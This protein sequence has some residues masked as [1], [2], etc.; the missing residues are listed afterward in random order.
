M[1]TWQIWLLGIG[2]I[3]SSVGACTVKTMTGTATTDTYVDAAAGVKKGVET[4]TS[5]NAQST[6]ATTNAE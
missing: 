1:K 6:A 4:I 5:A 2:I 3:L